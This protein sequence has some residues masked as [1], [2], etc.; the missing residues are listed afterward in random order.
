[1]AYLAPPFAVQS[2]KPMRTRGKY[3]AGGPTGAI[4][5]FNG[6]RD[7]AQACINIGIANHY[8]Y[9]S[10]QRDGKLVVAH[11]A[12]EWG[13]HCGE[14][15][16][17]GLPSPC[18]SALLGIEVCAAGPV[19]DLGNGTARPWYNEPRYLRTLKP[20]RKERLSDDLPMADTRAL[21]ADTDWGAHGLYHAYTKVQEETLT[22]TLHWLKTHFPQTFKFE[23]CLGHSEVSGRKGLGWW[24]KVDPSSALSVP[25]PAYRTL[26]AASWKP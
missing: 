11:N 23:F 25:L 13:A 19:R 20:P 3:K 6:G 10:I 21:L 18:H 2:T 9:W 26:L 8:V 22:Q 7:G 17:P 24:R 16:W 1:M 5:H 12:D 4:I 15:K 14:S